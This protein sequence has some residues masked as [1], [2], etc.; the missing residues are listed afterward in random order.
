MGRRERTA[1]VIKWAEKLSGGGP[2]PLSAVGFTVEIA[3]RGI[4]N[5]VG[6]HA[7]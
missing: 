7:P 6:G 5:R 3:I 4:V 2:L 1:P